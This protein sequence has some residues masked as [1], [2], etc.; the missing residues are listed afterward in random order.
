[1]S[2]VKTK[3]TRFSVKAG[4]LERK[5]FDTLEEAKDFRMDLTVLYANSICIIKERRIK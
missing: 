1:M 2:E 5:Y 3:R 4:K